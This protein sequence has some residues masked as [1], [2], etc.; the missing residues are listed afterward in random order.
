MAKTETQTY[1]FLI[2]N[3]KFLSSGFI[4]TYN[5]R[6]ILFCLFFSFRTP[7][8]SLYIKTWYTSTCIYNTLR[9]SLQILRSA[10]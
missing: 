10:V 8:F 2:F 4:Q 9:S 7:L 3:N 1:Y 5:Y 6:S